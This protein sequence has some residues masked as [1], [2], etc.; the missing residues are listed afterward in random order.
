MQRE[1]RSNIERRV[2]NNVR[3]AGALHLEEIA[4]AGEITVATIDDIRPISRQPSLD[5]RIRYST[6]P[7]TRIPDAA[8][9]FLL[10]EQPFAAPKR[11]YIMLMG[12][13]FP[14]VRIDRCGLDGGH[15]HGLTVTRQPISAHLHS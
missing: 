6:K 1:Q 8:L 7:A 15:A 2:A 10:G 14:R 3:R 11:L 13:T 12:F 9:E 5:G 4:L